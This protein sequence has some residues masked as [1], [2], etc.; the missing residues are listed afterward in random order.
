MIESNLYI[1]QETL[2]KNGCQLT[3][4]DIQSDPVTVNTLTS[5]FQ[6][7]GRESVDLNLA[8]Y[9]HKDL[10]DFFSKISKIDELEK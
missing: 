1:L 4:L 9:S 6:V 7:A 3:Q 8:F 10:T 2:K 5:S